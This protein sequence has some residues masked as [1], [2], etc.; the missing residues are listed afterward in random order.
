MTGEEVSKVASGVVDGLKQQ[1]ALLVIVVLNVLMIAAQ[2]WDA[3]A[4]TKSRNEVI[5]K[6]IDRCGPRGE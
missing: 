6:L 1:P 5:S 4:T 3:S 2:V